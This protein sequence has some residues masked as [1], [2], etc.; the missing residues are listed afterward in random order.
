[1]DR[2][3]AVPNPY[4]VSSP[5]ELYVGTT[6]WNRKEIR[7]INLPEECTIDIYTLTG[8]RIRTI[9]HKDNTGGFKIPTKTIED[10][11]ARFPTGVGE[12]TWDLLTYENLEVSYGMY[13]YVVKT[14]VRGKEEKFTE[15]LII[16]K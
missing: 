1:M 7:F 3:V 6:T 15:K 4:V 13:I 16:I 11:L 12:A 5:V 2:I 8:D 10:H 14:N 9:E